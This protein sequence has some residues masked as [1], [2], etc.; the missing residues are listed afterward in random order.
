MAQWL[1]DGKGTAPRADDRLA[2]SAIGAR[3]WREP[4]IG[5]TRGNKINNY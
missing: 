5:V 2:A 3:T 4:N 1:T